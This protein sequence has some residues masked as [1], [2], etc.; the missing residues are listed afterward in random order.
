MLDEE[1]MNK[2][3][4]KAALDPEFRKVFEQFLI[5]FCRKRRFFVKNN[6]L[7][8]IISTKTLLQQAFIK[9]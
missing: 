2:L 8:N 9:F 1:T 3:I 4:A 6:E 7:K 5:I